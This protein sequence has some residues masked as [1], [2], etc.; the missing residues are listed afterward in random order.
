MMFVEELA[1]WMTRG[2]DEI[3][4]A[5]A[6]VRNV[7][8]Q[9]VRIEDVRFLPIGDACAHEEDDGWT[10]KV[11]SNLTGVRLR[12]ALIHEA[13]EVELARLGYIGDVEKLAEMVT[14]AIVM[15]RAAFIRAAWRERLCHYELAR[16][17]A[18][19]QT[20]TVLRFAEVGLVAGSAVVH[21]RFVFA[22]G[23]LP[24]DEQRL[25]E[26]PVTDAPRRK[27]LWAA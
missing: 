2:L 24:K 8:G 27:A 25:V 20:A 10:I 6:V 23:T 9:D 13:V 15:P 18:A 17:F 3:P 19:S 14:G 4:G 21:P 22:R 1:A 11:R 7:L 12:W 26:R 5:R 16:A